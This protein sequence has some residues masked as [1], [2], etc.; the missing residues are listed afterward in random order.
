M[1][2]PTAAKSHDGHAVEPIKRMWLG[3]VEVGDYHVLGCESSVAGQSFILS[4]HDNVQYFNPAFSWDPR[5]K[6]ARIH[7]SEKPVIFLS[8]RVP[9]VKYR[10]GCRIH[11]GQHT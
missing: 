9:R 7:A 4:T 5:Q 6:E 8:Q 1:S 2:S 3:K 11:T 10:R